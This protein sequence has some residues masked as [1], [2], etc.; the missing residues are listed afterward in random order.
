M[1]NLQGDLTRSKQEYE[2][3]QSERTRISYVVSLSL[4]HGLIDY[5]FA[6]DV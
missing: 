2:N 4:L 1:T 3:Q 5:Y 6:A